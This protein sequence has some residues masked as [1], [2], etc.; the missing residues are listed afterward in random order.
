VSLRE[1]IS[2]KSESISQTVEEKYP[3]I[4]K[5]SSYFAEVWRETFPNEQ[6]K[7]QSRIEMRRA[8]AKKQAQYTEEELLAM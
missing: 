3:R 1:R 2:N 7:V 8:A 6:N 4:H 5:A